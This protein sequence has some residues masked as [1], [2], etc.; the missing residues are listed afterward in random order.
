MDAVA[1]YDAFE[2]QL[3]EFQARLDSDIAELQEW[4][5]NFWER[6]R[7]PALEIVEYTIPD[8]EY[9]FEP[10]YFSP[11]NRR[12]GRDFF[13]DDDDLETLLPPSRRARISD[14][15]STVVVEGDYQFGDGNLY[16][17][18]DAETLV[19]DWEYLRD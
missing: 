9:D 13:D 12:R 14:D 3:A 6:N 11:S 2:V 5:D 18:D 17:D 7:P 10:A 16:G 8:E 1:E 15:D 4:R 19:G